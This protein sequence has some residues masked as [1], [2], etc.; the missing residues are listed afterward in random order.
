MVII[1][2]S[3]LQAKVKI[4][5]DRQRRQ[6]QQPTATSAATATATATAATVARLAIIS[7]NNAKSTQLRGQCQCQGPR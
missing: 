6:Q 3:E 7:A 5:P 4:S 1:M 2:Q